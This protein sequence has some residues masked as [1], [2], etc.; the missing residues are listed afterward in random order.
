MINNAGVM[1]PPY[2]VT[3]DGFELQFGTNHLGHFT[4]TAGLFDLIKNIDHSSVIRRIRD[5]KGNDMYVFIL[6]K[7]NKFGL[8]FF[9][10]FPN[11]AL[12]LQ[13]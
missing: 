1:I 5:I 2:S 7:A 6:Q 9:L 12:M 11:K 4:L 10:L 3:N 8:I 13:S